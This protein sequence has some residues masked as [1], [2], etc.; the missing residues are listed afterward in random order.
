MITVVIHALANSLIVFGGVL[1][2]LIGNAESPHPDI[3]LKTIVVSPD[4]GEECGS[5][6]VPLEA[7]ISQEPPTDHVERFESVYS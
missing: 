5:E 3:C 2:L 1:V 6:H 7:S 4:F